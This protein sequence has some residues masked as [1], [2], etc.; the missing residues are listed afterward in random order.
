MPS[1]RTPEP[2]RSSRD[3]RKSWTDEQSRFW[4]RVGWM[5]LYILFRYWIR[6]F[7]VIGVE[8]VPEGGG[9]FL[10]ANHTSAMDPFIFGLSITQRMVRGPGKVELFKNPLVSWLI[11]RIGIF[12]LRRESVDTAAVRTM[13][14]LYRSGSLIVVFPEGRRSQSDEILPFDP[15]F[16]RLVIK[17]KAPL[18]PAGIAGA[19]KM[20][21]VGAYIP[22]PHTPVT[23][24]FGE[25][26]TL[27][28]YYD[29]ELTDKLL[30]EAA[31]YMRD[32]VGEIVK[33]AKAVNTC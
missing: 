8:R 9:M 19:G 23:V 11:R 14:E 17:L 20:L 18:F 22:R 16:A 10:I 21:P 12:P 24:A 1:T 27:S 25:E 5:L 28:Q 31:A 7:K 29:R 15:D 3:K 6:C 2:V 13:L 33:Q 30:E 32:R 4:Y 26:F